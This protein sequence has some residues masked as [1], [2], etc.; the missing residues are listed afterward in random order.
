MRR[1][2]G[3]EGRE[4][5]EWV[6]RIRKGRLTENYEWE[7]HARKIGRKSCW[8]G[9][10]GSGVEAWQNTIKDKEKKNI[11]RNE[12]KYSRKLERKGKCKVKWKKWDEKKGKKTTGNI[13][14]D[15]KRVKKK[16]K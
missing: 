16:K 8:K 11:E 15:N 12:W 10:D 1:K 9:K 6:K 3:E 13:S 4:R 14:W 5:K 2:N 7:C